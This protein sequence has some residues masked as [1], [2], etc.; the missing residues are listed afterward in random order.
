MPAL[1][2]MPQ[3]QMFS[4]MMIQIKIIQNWRKGR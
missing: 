4:L 3:R 2:S 1:P